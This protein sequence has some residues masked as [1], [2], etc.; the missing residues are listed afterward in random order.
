MSG[1]DL[2]FGVAGLIMAF[3]GAVD[4]A[5]WIQ[6]FSDDAKEGCGHLALRYHIETIR[7]RVWGDLCKVNPANVEQCTLQ[8]RPAYIKEAV[9][10]ILGEI[11]KLNE[12]AGRLVEKHKIGMPE[13][14]SR[15][16][17]G[18]L[19]AGVSLHRIP[20][21]YP[22]KPKARFLWT[23]KRKADFEKVVSKIQALNVDLRDFTL[24]YDEPQL[25][26]KALLS[27]VIVSVNDHELLKILADPGYNFD[28][29]LA[30]SALA[31]SLQ[32]DQLQQQ[33]HPPRSL[34]RP[35]FITDKDLKFL[36]SSSTL[37]I[38]TQQSGTMLTVWIE[39]NP[40]VTGNRWTEYVE[41]IHSLGYQL[42]RLG[43]CTLRLPT[44]YGVYDDLDYESKYGTKRIGYV[45]GPPQDHTPHPYDGDLHTKPP[46]TLRTL[47]K[48]QGR[49]PIP[50]LG[51]RFQLAFTLASAFSRFHA[52]GWLH[53]GLH[54]G[55]IVF[56]ERDDDGG[57]S[58]T[59]PFIT[60]FQYSRPQG[61]IS[62]SRGPLEDRKLQHYYH[63]DADMGFSKQRDLYGLGVVL[64]EV[65]C[66][67][68][69][70]NSFKDPRKMPTDRAAWRT[71][72][73]DRV[74]KDLGWRMGT[75]YQKVVMTLLQ[76]RLP[77]DD[78]T[79]DMFFVQQYLEKVIRPLI[80]CKA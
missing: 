5:L 35:S 43:G 22:V 69:V 4:G 26:T 64:Y 25:L 39:W 45:F 58:V 50:P 3:K 15:D 76:D 28:R 75:A 46:K 9:V 37:G 21:K 17:S 11:G 33:D 18:D 8:D 57:I 53:K 79:D 31:K 74:V 71:Y 38:L 54:S 48:N 73:V 80:A 61:E 62:Q 16:S 7:L 68:L 20:A 10:R 23:L 47:I 2:G 29:T 56:L 49:I 51:D 78:E 30:V 14:R 77:N 72:L 34:R 44:C 65:G 41:W 55:N 60:G 67:G 27:H 36:T 63:P 13:L 70:A 24:H 19:Q 59:E 12:E 66:W 32:Q 6:S 1:V 52:A 42:E 40:V